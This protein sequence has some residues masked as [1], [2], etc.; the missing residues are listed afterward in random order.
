M[1]TMQLTKTI[2]SLIPD[3]EP[4]SF[5]QIPN[6]MAI[7][8]IR[9]KLTAADWALWSYLQMID[10]FG[11]R[12]VELPHISEIASVIDISE[13][14]VKRSLKKL[15]DLELYAWEPVVIRGQNLA[16]KQ[17]RELFQK[18]K[19]TKASNNVNINSDKIKMTDL[20]KARQNCPSGDKIV[21]TG[22][23]SSNNRQNCPN[24]ELEPLPSKACEIS[25][26]YS[27]FKNT[28]SKEEREDFL[29]FC[30]KEVEN[31]PTKIVHL[32]SW[33]ASI[34]NKTGIKRWSEF[35]SQYQAS[36]T[37]RS[38]VE[39]ERKRERSAWEQWQEKIRLQK[40]RAA[41]QYESQVDRE[42]TV[43][44]KP[45]ESSS[46]D[47]TCD[48]NIETHSESDSS[49]R[50]SSTLSDGM[51]QQPA[52][53]IDKPYSSHS[54]QGYLEQILYS[55]ITLTRE[56]QQISKPVNNNRELNTFVDVYRQEL[57][58]SS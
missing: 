35:Y 26:T 39:S 27:D 3:V 13:R 45:A 22:T 52:E 29:D 38:K 16:G 20:S 23:E 54:S 56:R 31:Y 28:L 12:M 55:E 48:V 43:E 9:A 34:D 44:E 42:K 4:N 51:Q 2:N 6:S 41:Q 37:Q 33:L 8:A 53:P 10:P 15:E 11:D 5:Y 50:T 36:L 47:S 14:Q 19:E 25:H 32:E 7:K 1:S 24:E 17:V 21:Q 46:T 30:R 18:K 57:S 49:V 40:S 58:V